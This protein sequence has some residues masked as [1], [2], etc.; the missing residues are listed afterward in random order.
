M[1]A[2]MPGINKIKLLFCSCNINQLGLMYIIDYCIL[3]RMFEKHITIVLSDT[4]K[5]TQTLKD[6][7]CISPTY[8]PEASCNPPFSR[9]VY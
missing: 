1:E 6:T 4:N 9:T 5:A 7:R 3:Y 8:V 2:K